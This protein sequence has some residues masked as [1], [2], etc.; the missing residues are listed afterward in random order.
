[1]KIA[2]T[3]TEPSLD[4]TVDPR[5]GRC[6]YFLIVDAEQETFEALENTNAALGGGAGIQSA[7]MIANAGAQLLLTG[8]CG[9]NAFR[10]LSAAGIQVV[11]GCSGSVRAAIEQFKSGQLEAVGEPTVAAHTGTSAPTPKDQAVPNVTKAPLPT[12]E[13]RGMGLGQGMGYG[14][15]IGRGAGRGMGRGGGVGRGAGRQ[16]QQRR[17]RGQ[18]R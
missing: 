9:P 2:V 18:N 14:G 8:N 1:M 11:P 15:G 10:T 7:Q 4:A 12:N 3:A 5:F 16:M 17:R 13:G 6:A